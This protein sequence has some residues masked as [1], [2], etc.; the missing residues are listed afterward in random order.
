M[1]ALDNVATTATISNSCMGVSIRGSKNRF[2][3]FTF[4][5]HEPHVHIAIWRHI[6]NML[7]EDESDAL[8]FMCKLF[9]RA[10]RHRA[11][12]WVLVGESGLTTMLSAIIS[13]TKFR[14]STL[15]RTGRRFEIRLPVGRHRLGWIPVASERCYIGNGMYR[16]LELE[17][18]D[19][20]NPLSADERANRDALNRA[21]GDDVW[22]WNLRIVT[23]DITAVYSDDELYSV[24]VHDSVAKINDCAFSGCVSLSR[25]KFPTGLNKIGYAAFSSCNELTT[26]VFSSYAGHIKLGC[27]CF[28]N[29][30]KLKF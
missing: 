29:C 7:S 10:T 21:F 15:G 1:N 20:D 19:D 3:T 14:R 22:V 16:G 24:V 30:C 13:Y 12:V 4:G 23:P 17:D 9:A 27:S 26:V 6:I 8:R 25:V 5:K 28:S 11:P 2:P 18:I